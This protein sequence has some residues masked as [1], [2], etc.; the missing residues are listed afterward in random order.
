MSDLP[1][2]AE[3]A[4]FTLSAQHSLTRSWASDEA[5]LLALS[6]D[7]EFDLQLATDLEL[8]AGRA[9]FFDVG[10]PPAAY[11]NRW[12]T[13]LPGLD[14]MLSVR[15]EGLEVTRPFVDATVLSRPLAAADLP[16]LG[17]A[18]RQAYGEFRPL[19]LRL[20]SAEAAGHF[21]G[22]QPDRRFL[23]APVGWL[24]G[25][26]TPPGLTLRPT[27]DLTHYAQ[28]QA[29]YAAVDA[30]H[31]AHV[32]QAGLQP[33]DELQGS[34]DAGT[35]FD[36]LVRGQWAGY[37]GATDGGADM[38]GLP[39][40]V[41]QEI[42]LSPQYRGQGYGAHLTTLLARALPGADRVLLGTVHAENRGARGAALRAGRLDLGGWVQWPLAL[43]RA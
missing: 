14:A 7:H 31:P 43:V 18:A 11:L 2:A 38:L 3:L 13:V 33:A 37:V 19:Y 26:E 17:A 24:R 4:V 35:L 10:P 9:G 27:A 29:A 25:G 1:T 5:R 6:S 30:Q 36:V 12:V 39:A 15:F 23:G 34:I 42:I 21:A 40:S 8:A 16:A 22:T 41:V 20:W 28:A 32:R